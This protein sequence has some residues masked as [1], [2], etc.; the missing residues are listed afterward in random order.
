MKI[1]EH[2]EKGFSIKKCR[3]FLVDCIFLIWAHCPI[4]PLTDD[5]N[6]PSLEM[7][8]HDSDGK[9]HNKSIRLSILGFYFGEY[10]VFVLSWN[11]DQKKFSFVKKMR[12]RGLPTFNAIGEFEHECSAFNNHVDK[13]VQTG[14]NDDVLAERDFL[15]KELD[16]Q[17]NRITR[18]DSKMVIY[19]AVALAMIPL[20]GKDIYERICSVGICE[21]ILLGVVVYYFANICL[22]TIQYIGVQAVDQYEF[23]KIS[24]H[25]G[26]VNFFLL[27][28]MY[29]NYVYKRNQARLMVSSVCRIVDF[30]KL[31]F[32]FIVVY[33]IFVFAH[34]QLI[35]PNNISFESKIY[36]LKES[37]INEIYSDD[38][39]RLME[40]EIL[41]E[42]KNY[43]RVV[44]MS[45]NSIQKPLSE[46]ISKYAKQKITYLLD[47]SLDED[48]IKILLEN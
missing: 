10:V 14:N 38:R 39:I 47:E 23:K 26:P 11:F 22:L 5:E 28:K 21:K 43:K 44:V 12:M 25:D 8:I 45:K 6:Y 18:T 36:V 19:S 1:S 35:Q 41:L 20:F 13:L 29:Y 46:E 4:L 17:T 48:V 40:L 27:K 32:I 3:N 31:I 15:N 24:E 33:I 9:R 37:K 42:K 2:I 7:P 16:C 30:L 34:N